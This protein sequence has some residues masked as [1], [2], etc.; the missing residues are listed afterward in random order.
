[1]TARYEYVDSPHNELG[2]TNPVVKMCH[3]LDVSP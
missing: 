2:N 3:W 1:V